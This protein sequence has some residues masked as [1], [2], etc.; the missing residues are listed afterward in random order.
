MTD[1]QAIVDDI[2][3]VDE[4]LRDAY[5]PMESGGFRLKALEGFVAEDQVTEHD[6]VLNLKKTMQK[7]RE[8]AND[9]EKKIKGL[10]GNTVTEEEKKELADLRAAKAKVEEDRRRREGE[11]DKWR[12]DIKGAHAKEIEGIVGERDQLRR[13]ICEDAVSLQI[14]GAC[15]E[16][17]GR[18]KILEPVIRQSVQSEFNPET[19]RVE[20]SILDAD[21]TKILDEDGKPLSI[22]GFV[23]RLSKDPEYAELFESTQRSGGGSSDSGRDDSGSGGGEKPKTDGLKRSE[24]SKKDKATFIHEHGHDEY[25]KLPL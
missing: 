15:N 2:E 24:M 17:K 10:E 11:F 16:L 19:G 14:S 20:I 21:G 23:Q 6:S 25:M 13:A 5:A 7:E 3:S 22:M 12:E 18:A 8:R 1:I 4:S 9:L